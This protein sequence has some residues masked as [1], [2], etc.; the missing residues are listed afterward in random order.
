[1]KRLRLTLNA[2]GYFNDVESN[3]LIFM[4]NDNEDLQ[5]FV[6]ESHIIRRKVVAHI[7]LSESIITY[8][9]AGVDSI[10]HAMFMNNKRNVIEVF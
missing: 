8:L 5:V 7:H 1:M 3:H 9:K 2:Y 10:E 6:E 4:S